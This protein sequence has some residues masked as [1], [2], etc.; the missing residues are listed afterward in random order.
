MFISQVHPYP[1]TRLT[2]AFGQVYLSIQLDLSGY[3]ARQAGR[4]DRDSRTGSWLKCA[5]VLLPDRNSR[6]Y[7]S[8]T[9]FSVD[10][11]IYDIKWVYNKIHEIKM[12]AKIFTDFSSLISNHQSHIP[13]KVCSL[14]GAKQ[15]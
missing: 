1:G 14:I 2:I 8:S 5:S 11:Q 6:V 13:P 15:R 12:G 9:E 7:F 3:S 4:T 10:F